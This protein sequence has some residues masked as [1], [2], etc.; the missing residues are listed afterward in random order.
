MLK[1]KGPLLIYIMLCYLSPDALPKFIAWTSNYNI[2][3]STCFDLNVFVSKTLINTR[4]HN[5][6]LTIINSNESP[7]C[8]SLQWNHN[9]P[10]SAQ[11]IINCLCGCYVCFFVF[12]LNQTY[13]ENC[14]LVQQENLKNQQ[15]TEKNISSSKRADILLNCIKKNANF[16]AHKGYHGDI[17]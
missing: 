5:N 16:W 4:M 10:K 7:S 3:V 9:K 14:F 8:F 17:V 1:V 15:T 13:R 6:N 12:S 2:F 11:A